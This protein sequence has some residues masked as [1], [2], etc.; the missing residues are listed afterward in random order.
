M[1]SN[2]SAS[3]SSFSSAAEGITGGYTGDSLT[4]KVLIAFFLGLSLYN[5]VE[6]QV[7]IFGTF[8]KFR[9]LYFWSLL[10][11]SIGIVPYSIGFLFK[12]FLILKHQKWFSL[13]LL[14]IGWYPMITGQAVVLYSRLHLLLTGGRRD[15][16]LK[17]TKWMIIVDAICLHIPTT[18]LTIGS[19]IDTHTEAF[20]DGYN[21]MEKVQM[22]GFFLQEVILSS[23]YIIEAI[24]ILRSS[25]Q[26]NTKRLMY[27]LLAINVLIITLD[28]GLLG[29]ECASLYILETITK[30]AFYSIKLKLEFAILGKLVDFVGGKNSSLPFAPEEKRTSSALDGGTDISEFVDLTKVCT[31]VTRTSQRRRPKSGSRPHTQDPD[32]DLEIAR[33]EHV[34]TLPSET[35]IPNGDFASAR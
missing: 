16:I 29:L 27:Q 28:L 13:L 21:V 3:S 18:V 32:L 31:D 35:R 24:R 6:L 7:L 1:A 19:N 15:K 2:S 34:E 12:Y 22:C 8:K 26:M 14:S 25:V 5:A 33:L 11:S 20:V 17:W 4:I 9:G 10:I 23:I 30:P